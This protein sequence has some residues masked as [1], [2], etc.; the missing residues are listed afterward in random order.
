MD[1]VQDA[2]VEDMFA[3]ADTYA[4]REAI[5]A[6]EQAQMDIQSDVDAQIWY[7]QRDSEDLASMMAAHAL[8]IF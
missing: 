7:A 4:E 1:F 8:G 3:A 6:L 2:K 5:L